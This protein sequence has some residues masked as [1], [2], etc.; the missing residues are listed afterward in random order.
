MTLR[1]VEGFEGVLKETA[2][3]DAFLD[4]IVAAAEEIAREG[5]FSSQGPVI[6][7]AGGSAFYDRVAARF[8]RPTTPQ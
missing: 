3:V 4:S 6:L 5:L 8:A 2:A 1:G 7:S